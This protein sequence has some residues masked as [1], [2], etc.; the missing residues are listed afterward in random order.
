[1]KTLTPKRH[2]VD[3]LF[4]IALFG[5]FAASALLVVL[6]G[7]NVYKSTVRGMNANFNMQTSLTYVSAKV[8]QNDTE[9]AISLGEISGLPALVLKQTVG[10]NVY[11]TL[12]YEYDGKL[13]EI[14]TR[15]D[16]PVTPSEGNAIMDVDSFNMEQLENGLFRFSCADSGGETSE[17]T[18]RARCSTTASPK[19][20]TA[21]TAT[22]EVEA[23]S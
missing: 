23:V 7:A 11:H 17:V 8:R 21:E 19:A 9:N 1:M 4:T 13:C 14:F 16:N 3:L 22:A 15:A 10:E 5:V 6:I 2:V 20:A 12:I 18:V